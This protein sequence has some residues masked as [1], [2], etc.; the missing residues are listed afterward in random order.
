MLLSSLKKPGEG[1][2]IRRALLKFERKE[3]FGSLEEVLNKVN[4]LESQERL[5]ETLESL[6]S[7]GKGRIDAAKSPES[8]E[9][10]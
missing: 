6:E 8:Q 1:K 10:P 5:Q 4:C 7:L 2:K 3:R 9:R